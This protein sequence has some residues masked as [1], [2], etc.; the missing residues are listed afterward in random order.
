MIASLLLAAALAVPF[1]GGEVFTYEFQWM[2]IH[3]GAMTLR[4]EDEG[5]CWRFTMES[6]TR[7]AGAKI[8]PI[9][10]V[11]VSL[12]RKSDFQTLFFRKHEKGKKG[13]KIDETLFAPAEGLFFYRSF[14]AM[15]EP[16]VDTLSFMHY[17][18]L[19]QG[20]KSP[21]PKAYD[22]GRLYGLTFDKPV[23]EDI[24]LGRRTVGALRV[25]PHLRDDRDQEKKGGMVL[26]YSEDSRRVPL[27]VDFSIPIGTLKA[28]LD[29]AP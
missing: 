12:V 14:R 17:L 15:T 8:Y 16:C 5:D 29:C 20:W 18:R 19:P 3:V 4:T 22:R 24:V 11:L 7:G 27:A 23:R 25:V 21:P 9:E 10:E 6:A 26:W 2:G 13:E 1:E 28:R